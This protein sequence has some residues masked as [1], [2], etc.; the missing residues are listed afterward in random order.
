MNMTDSDTYTSNAERHQRR[1]SRGF[2]TAYWA[3]LPVFAVIAWY[4][5]RDSIGLAL[6]L[7]LLAVA[8]PTAL[9][10]LRAR[11]IW[12]PL[13]LAIGGAVLSGGLI[14]LGGGMIE[15]HFHI[16]VLLPLLAMFGRPT[17]NIVGA[18]AVALHHVGMFFWRPESLFN[19]TAGFEIVV[20]HAVFVVVA[21]VPG[22]Y[23]AKW[24]GDY[25]IGA[26]ALV[27]RLSE[28]GGALHQ[29]S[30]EL[31]SAS[32]QLA[33]DANQQ[34]AAV[35]EISAS[36]QEITGQSQRCSTELKSAQSQQVVRLR[37]AIQQIQQAG[38][39]IDGT[40]DGIAKSSA[41]IT[42][43]VKT[44]E[45][46]AFQ[47]NILALNAAVEAARAGAAGA[48]FSVVA[49]EVRNLAGRAAEAAGRTRE[50]I[51]DAANSGREGQGASAELGERVKIVTTSFGEM[52]AVVSRAVSLMAEQESGVVQI[53]E[54]MTHVDESA[55]AS[56]A[57]SEELSASALQLRELSGEVA[58]ALN[59]MMRTMGY[60]VDAR[61]AKSGPPASPPF[62]AGSCGATLRA[63]ANAEA[64][65]VAA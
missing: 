17:V 39:K 25:I 7:G 15:M 11:G 60:E 55:Q 37:G 6:S 57:R 50:L 64:Y 14:H 8:G 3:H 16:F 65:S 29:T 22:C 44:I 53:N 42:G 23:L 19:Y 49:G 2:L 27:E 32:S 24:F 33:G 26:G 59:A 13:S 43:I 47:T 34:A 5:G 61:A 38:G 21:T 63:G 30:S 36:L 52:E 51:E 40:M 41:A 20:L 62:G 31:T 35:E 46:I 54:S 58:D 4:T 10:L 45:E 18:A 12:T 28:A 9:F 48:G 56:S 1:V